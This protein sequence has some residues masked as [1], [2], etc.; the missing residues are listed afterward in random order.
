MELFSLI[1][2]T[3]S[4]VYVP[5]YSLPFLSPLIAHS[6]GLSL[7]LNWAAEVC[8]CVLRFA[9]ARRKMKKKREE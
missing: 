2:S 8:T 3:F 9:S 4:L 1:L 5:F 7:F 6:S